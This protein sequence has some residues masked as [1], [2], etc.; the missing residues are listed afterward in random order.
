[1]RTAKKPSNAGHQ[2]EALP[3][4]KDPNRYPKGWDRKRVEEVIRYY[5]NQSDEDAI[6]EAEEAYRSNQVTMMAVPNE[7][8]PKV[9]KLIA[10]LAS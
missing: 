8:V 10:K 9:Q 1:M 4:R 6:A 7:L 3:R 2:S 5:E